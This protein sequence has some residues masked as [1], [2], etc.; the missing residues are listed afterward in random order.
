M[1]DLDATTTLLIASDHGTIDRGGSG[2]AEDLSVDIPLLA[3]RAGSQLGMHAASHDAQAGSG[4]WRTVDVAPTVSALL[5]LP[6]PRQSEGTH[7][8]GGASSS[9]ER[10]RPKR[11]NGQEYV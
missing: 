3:Y 1:R 11:L 4:G 2:G 6:V 5:G 10:K 7:R 9:H 8:V